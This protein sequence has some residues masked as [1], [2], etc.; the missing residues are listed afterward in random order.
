[1]KAMILLKPEANRRAIHVKRKD[2]L[3]PKAQILPTENLE[4]KYTPK[5]PVIN[6]ELNSP[7]HI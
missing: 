1:M 7:F 6:C 3:V 5:F 2:F 4:Y